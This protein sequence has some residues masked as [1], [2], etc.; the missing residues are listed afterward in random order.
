MPPLLQQAQDLAAQGA[1]GEGHRLR[2]A[3]Y[4][5][6]APS[7]S[8]LQ[9]VIRRM[10]GVDLGTRESYYRSGMK[11]EAP[12]NLPVPADDPILID[13]YYSLMEALQ[14][15]VKPYRTPYTKEMMKPII[16]KHI[17]IVG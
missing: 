14:V 13:R 2:E 17:G 6:A 9:D 16:N 1:G 8:D 12:E 7:I 15:P 4:E 10:K 3:Y 11:E 5:A